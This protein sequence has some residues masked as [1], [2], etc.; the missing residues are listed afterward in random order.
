MAHPLLSYHRPCITSCFFPRNSFP[1]Q[2][3]Q[4]LSGLLATRNMFRSL[5][6]ICLTAL[7]VDS[8]L[9]GPMEMNSIGMLSRY[10]PGVAWIYFSQV[11][12][13]TPLCENRRFHERFTAYNRYEDEVLHFCL[14]AIFMVYESFIGLASFNAIPESV[15]EYLSGLVCS[16]DLE[17]VMIQ[18][19]HAFCATGLYHSLCEGRGS[20]GCG[21]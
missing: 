8:P 13:D 21:I 4:V 10:P 14:L 5:H 18:L 17:G 1:F 11:C 6:F 2:T 3:F 12:I 20:V 9:K 7:L 15:E 16:M 19:G